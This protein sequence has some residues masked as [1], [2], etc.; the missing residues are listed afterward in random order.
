M[1]LQR[2]VRRSCVFVLSLVAAGA[3]AQPVDPFAETLESVRLHSVGRWRFADLHWPEAF[4][5][6]VAGRVYRN[7][8]EQNFR[9]VVRDPNAPAPQRERVTQPKADEPAP[10]GSVV[11]LRHEVDEATRAVIDGLRD[12][13]PSARGFRAPVLGTAPGVWPFDVPGNDATAPMREA[14]DLAMASLTTEGLLATTARCVEILRNEGELAPNLRAIGLPIDL[15][16]CFT[17]SGGQTG[18]GIIAWMAAQMEGGRAAAELREEL[19]A[20]TFRWAPT[21]EGYRV[22]SESGEHEFGAMRLQLTRGDDWLAPGDGG[23]VDVLRQMVAA[24]PGVDF[25]A[26]IEPEFVDTFLEVSRQ[27]PLEREKRMTL[28]VERLEKITQWA[29]D[30]AKP[31]LVFGMTGEGERIVGAASLAPRYVSLGEVG[32]PF[33][34]GDNFLLD[35][36]AQA[37]WRVEQSRLLF[38]GGDLMAVTEPKSGAR[39]L[40][41]GEAQLHRNESLG[42]TREQALDAFRAEFGV[43][44]CVIVPAVSFHLDYEVSVRAVGDELVAFVNDSDAAARMIIARGLSVMAR[45]E[46][47]DP[48][49]IP[50]VLEALRDGELLTFMRMVGGVRHFSHYPEPFAETFS[51]GP[52]DMGAGNLQRFLLAMDRVASQSPALPE[53]APSEAEIAYLQAMQRRDADREALAQSLSALGWKV[54]RVPSFA[55]GERSVNYLNGVHD[56]T[57]YLMPAWGG[58]FKGL[59]DAAEKVFR[60]ALGPDVQVIPILTSES[61]RR[62]GAVRC[63]VEVRPKL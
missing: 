63:S 15:L 26:S 53:H 50:D 18:E 9:Q 5:H 19:D 43:D 44:R 57:R 59:D 41:I 60:E 31:G 10:E 1:T 13:T 35:G 12:G 37:Q 28:I 39:F 42:L 52:G 4:T 33:M 46:L 55:E 20:A 49:V 29:Q 32:T 24:L 38:Q 22:V 47:A 36:L 25:T 30:S 51:T 14:A 23:S 8:Y 56:R 54:V 48:V 21:I 3:S 40:L 34:Q 11:V 27:W 2:A 6:R 45:Q 58:L 16:D 62:N 17:L 61:Q 7:W